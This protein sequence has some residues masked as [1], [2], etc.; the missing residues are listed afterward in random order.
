MKSLPSHCVDAY[1]IINGKG[2]KQRVIPL[3]EDI[4]NLLNEYIKSIPETII[5]KAQTKEETNSIPLFIGEEGGRLCARV[6]QRLVAKIR[7]DLNLDESF[8]PHAFR[9]SFATH[10]LKEGVNLRTIQE[11]LGHSSLV[12]TQ[13]YLK[14]DTKELLKTHQTFHPRSKK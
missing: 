9:H 5:L 2:G 4:Y 10:L 13:R 12:A 6:V 11:L 8:T 3:L 1:L 14:V 7:Y